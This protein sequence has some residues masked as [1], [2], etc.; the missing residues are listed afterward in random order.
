[1]SKKIGLILMCGILIFSVSG[2][3]DKN[4]EKKSNKKENTESVE[5]VENADNS[6]A[7][8]ESLN[9]SENV[10]NVAVEEEAPGSNNSNVEQSAVVEEPVV[11]TPSCTP[12][13][14]DNTYSYVYSTKEECKSNGYSVFETLDDSLFSFG[15][16]EIVDECGTTWY[17]LYF[18]RYSDGSIVRVYY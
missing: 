8:D 17:G 15:C 2:C 5:V 3:K 12:K 6:N 10:T 14:F 9:N 18:L 13:K 11:E 7:S 1:M 4:V 16:D